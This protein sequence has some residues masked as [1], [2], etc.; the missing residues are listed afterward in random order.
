MKS[1]KVVMMVL[2]ALCMTGCAK[3]NETVEETAVPV[4]VL[5]V[6]SGVE[7]SAHT[8]VGTVE[9]TSS[10]LLSFEVP[11]TVEQL[12]ATEGQRVAK[13]QVL[14]RLDAAT[15]KSAHEAALSTLHQA[16][17]AHKRYGALHQGG[18]VTDIQW[19]EVQNKLQQA[20][21]AEQIAREQLKN[22]VLHAPASGVIA[23]RL[24]EQGM[25]VLPGQAVYKLVDVAQV[26]IRI[27]VPENEISQMDLGRKAAFTVAALGGRS[28]EAKVTEKGITAN[29][30]SHTYEV[31]MKLP[32]TD[33]QLMPGMV[34]EV[35]FLPQ[36][37][38][39]EIVIPARAVLLD[40]NGRRFVWLDKG[41]KA[42]RVYVQ[43]GDLTD[44]GIV[45]SSGLAEGDRVIT[46]GNQKVSEGMKLAVK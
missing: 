16:Q 26:N 30:L 37:G 5:T 1:V 34:C 11:G 9:E 44:K 7:A 33:S 21:S 22:T 4:K 3:K 41:G 32:N 36:D 35:R 29:P 15:L 13:G 19:V 17:D 40:E 39:N 18:T 43:T 27:A 28:Y 14:A 12:N 46:E 23:S 45:V 6:H 10:T 31:K 38:T 24:V 42:A 20:V 25:N 2:A 8:Y